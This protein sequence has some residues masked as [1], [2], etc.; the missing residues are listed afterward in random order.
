MDGSMYR[1]LIFGGLCFIGLLFV[2]LLGFRTYPVQEW[3]RYSHV[4]AFFR[5]KSHN[6]IIMYAPGPQAKKTEITWFGIHYCSPSITQQEP[7]PPDYAWLVAY[8]QIERLGWR[9]LKGPP[10]NWKGPDFLDHDGTVYMDFDTWSEVK[11]ATRYLP[12]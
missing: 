1:K 11:E 12:Q 6:L 8:P 5:D 2:V 7:W 3:H 9:Q 10:S 4:E